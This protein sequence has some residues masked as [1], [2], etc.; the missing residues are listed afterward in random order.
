MKNLKHKPLYNTM[1]FDESASHVYD[2]NGEFWRELDTL[3]RNHPEFTIT[4]EHYVVKDRNVSH[5]L[6]DVRV[7]CDHEE[8]QNICNQM[9]RSLYYR[10]PLKF[11]K[12]FEGR[13]DI[14]KEILEGQVKNGI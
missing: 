6:G 3:C 2:R 5:L 4:V 8:L 7:V 13:D 14:L 11:H 10:V 12:E 1:Y 9:Y